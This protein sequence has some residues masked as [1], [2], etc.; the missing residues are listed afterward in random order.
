MNGS[1]SGPSDGARGLRRVMEE[2]LEAPQVHCPFSILTVVRGSRRIRSLRAYNRRR[3]QR[4]N[5]PAL[6]WQGRKGFNLFDSSKVQDR[7]H[8]I[9]M[10]EEDEYLAKIQKTSAKSLQENDSKSGKGEPKREAYGGIP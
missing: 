2:I 10:Q 3:R 6:F 9:I 4:N 8:E 5:S 1:T 7:F